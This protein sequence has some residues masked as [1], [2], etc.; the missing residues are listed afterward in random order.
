MN[1]ENQN[2]VENYPNER[3]IIHKL[4]Q[5]DNCY[6]AINQNSRNVGCL[7]FGLDNQIVLSKLLTKKL[8]GFNDHEIKFESVPHLRHW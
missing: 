7:Y 8:S 1:T 4:N 6:Q 2:D 5:K 3:I